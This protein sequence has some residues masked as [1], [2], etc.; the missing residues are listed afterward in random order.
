MKNLQL[1]QV[2]TL[3][4]LLSL[5][6][7]QM[8]NYQ[9]IGLKSRKL[10]SKSYKQTL[11]IQQHVRHHKMHLN[12]FGPLLPEFMGGSADLAGS[13]LTLWDGSKGLEVKMMRQVTI[14]S[15]VY[16]NLVCPAIMN[17]IAL[18]KGFH[19]LRCYILDVYGVCT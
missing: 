15:M 11:Q 18:H 14:F 12:A 5:N 1:M 19:S 7:V 10:T 17:G 6:A 9:L 2:H 3:S 13:N 16:V 8:A 4:L